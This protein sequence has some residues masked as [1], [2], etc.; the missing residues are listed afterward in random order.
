MG[1]LWPHM[2]R[3]AG[4]SLPAGKF[5]PLLRGVIAFTEAHACGFSGHESSLPAEASNGS[6]A[7]ISDLPV[8]GAGRYTSALSW[9]LQKESI[10]GVMH[11]LVVSKFAE[12]RSTGGRAGG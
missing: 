12:V 3:A 1:S 9:G 6:G 10:K 4:A 7:R 11:V 5:G 2:P 8:F